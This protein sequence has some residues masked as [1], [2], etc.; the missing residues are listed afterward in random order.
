MFSI[1]EY[2][3]PSRPVVLLQIMIGIFDLGA[4]AL[5]MYVLLPPLKKESGDFPFR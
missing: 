2:Q 4:A 5:A 1:G 3:L